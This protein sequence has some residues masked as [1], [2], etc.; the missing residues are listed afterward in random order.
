METDQKQLRRHRVPCNELT[1]STYFSG[2]WAVLV[3]WTL[4][5][6][7]SAGPVF[8]QV[9]LASVRESADWLSEQE[10]IRRAAMIDNVRYS[11]EL[12]LTKTDVFSGSV[13]IDFD[14]SVGADRLTIDFSKGVVRSLT[15]NKRPLAIDYNQFFLS[16]DSTDLVEGRNQ[17]EVEFEHPYSDD[18]TG[19]YRFVDPVDQLAYLYSYLWPYYANRVFP[20]F[21]QPDLKARYELSVRAPSDWIVVSTA[22]ESRVTIPDADSTSR[23]WHF[24]ETAPLSTY[25]YSLHAGPYQ[26]WESKAGDIPLRLL[27]RRSLSNLVEVD[28][29]FDFTQQGFEFFQRYF[30]ISYPFEKYDQI[31]VP[32]FNIGAMENVAAVTFQEGYVYRGEPTR[33]ELES[34]ARVVLHEMAHMW[35]GDLVTKKWWNGLWLNESFATL[36]ATVALV[37]ATEFDDAWHSFYLSSKRSAY[38]ADA[39]VTT[40]PIEVPV[41]NTAAFFEVFDS[42]TY[43]KGASVLKQ[44]MYLVG[45]REF[46]NGVRA[47]L[48]KYAY[49][50][51]VLADF[52][53]AIGEASGRDLEGWSR[54]WLETAG[55]NTIAARAECEEGKVVRLEFAQTAP[56]AWP[57]LREHRTEVALY[58]SDVNRPA[59]MIDTSPLALAGVSTELKSELESPCPVLVFPNH[60]DW[61]YFRVVLDSSSL[62]AVKTTL[63]SIDDP[64]A[65]SMMWGSLWDMTMDGSLS[66]TRFA[67]FVLATLATESDAR[68]VVQALRYLDSTL[69][70]FHR[71]LPESKPILESYGPRIETFLWSGVERAPSGS[72]QQKI[73]FDQYVGAAH[74]KG[75]LD[76]LAELLEGKLEIEGLTL[77]Q[78]RRWR[79]LVRLTSW[80]Y[81]TA[82]EL[83]AIEMARDTSHSGTLWKI[84]VDASRPSLDTKKYWLGEFE[85]TSGSLPFGQQR[86]AMEQLFPA[87][88]NALQNTLLD[89]VL[90]PIPTMSLDRDAYFLTSYGYH[91]VGGACSA[92]A[93]DSISQILDSDQQLSS[94]I[95]R[96]L[97]ET[98]QEAERC[99][100]LEIGR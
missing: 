25:I 97:L 27:A 54:E 78:D 86:S 29:W 21:D 92:T 10:A 24:P 88:Q 18:G 64:L 85:K 63:P 11:I 87:H 91:L 55:T 83:K 71:R 79:L 47:Y 80:D 51:T 75:G 57:T 56:S 4:A 73:W 61:G 62:D 65:R 31:I 48:K 52:I 37:E 3:G 5:F 32:D 94:A 77:D 16:V 9:E 81:P 28:R 58:R 45:E 1:N 84:A 23:V 90:A 20:C 68:V 59:P 82:A 26:V 72:D 14:Y 93:A 69:G 74:T 49:G 8:A 36:M 34:L 67:D 19:L 76:R 100:G 66:L 12:D 41:D 99:I 22:Q 30:A 40:H 46:R 13:E 89:D 7:G 53:G 95:T 50:N 38:Y 43:G 42:I 2:A 17:I 96:A 70:S 6:A 35:F 15:V 39:L 60:D 44:L 33:A 98:R